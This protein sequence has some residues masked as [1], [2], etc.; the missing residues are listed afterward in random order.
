MYDY[1][2]SQMV[3]EDPETALDAVLPYVHSVHV[4]DDVLIKSEPDVELLVAGVPVGEG[5][6]PIENL[7]RRLLESGLRRFA[8]ENVWSYSAPIRRGRLA[9]SDVTVGEA[10]FQV[11]KQPFRPDRLL[12]RPASHSPADVLAWEYSALIRGL[13]AFHRTLNCTMPT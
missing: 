12:L 2:N 3:L 1:G 10:C 6:L 9:Q 8:F 4:K 11:L 13:A 7:T 5:F